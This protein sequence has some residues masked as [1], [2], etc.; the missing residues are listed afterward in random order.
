MGP[1]L[2]KRPHDLRAILPISSN[3]PE[4]PDSLLYP[5]F[6]NNLLSRSSTVFC[7]LWFNRPILLEESLNKMSNEK[8]RETHVYMAKLAEQAER[9]EGINSIYWLRCA[10]VCIVYVNFAFWDGSSVVSLIKNVKCMRYNG[11]I[12]T[13]I[14]V[15]GLVSA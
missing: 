6:P 10:S 7:E 13:E 11:S 9:Y 5:F 3:Q 15:C 8:E 12:S 4:G 14:L 1:D 2:M